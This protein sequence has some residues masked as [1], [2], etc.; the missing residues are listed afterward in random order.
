MPGQVFNL[1]KEFLIEQYVNQKKSAEKIAGEIGCAKITVLRTLKHF[2]IKRKNK[3][4][5]SNER[6]L[7]Q[8]FGF[9]VATEYCGK[10]K[11]SWFLWKCR[12]DCG[13]SIKVATTNLLKG[14]VKCCGCGLT[15]RG[16]YIGY[17][18]GR[19][20]CQIKR[21]AMVRELKFDITQ[22]YINQLF[23]QQN[24][25]CA[26]TG[27]EICLPENTKQWREGRYNASL[28]RIDSSIG[29]VVGNVQWVTKKANLMK[30]QLS[31]DEFVSI[32]HK[33]SNYSKRQTWVQAISI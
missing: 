16:K 9:L 12:C 19:M 7:Q 10:D 18:S 25:R 3:R 17:V 29:Y 20:W 33:V 15:K 6:I 30:M 24:F 26:L 22:D 28:D 8:R 31:Q 32:C 5:K 21:C 14:A 13:G 2:N 23:I 11:N 27:E 1:T 4:E